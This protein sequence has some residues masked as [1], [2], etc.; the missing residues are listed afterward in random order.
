VEKKSEAVAMPALIGI[1][2]VLAAVYQF[3][4]R[5]EHWPSQKTE[6]VFYEHDNLTGET[7]MTRANAR[8]SVFARIVG[9]EDGEVIGERDSE[10]S[11]E[12]SDHYLAPMELERNDRLQPEPRL[13]KQEVEAAVIAQD[14]PKLEKLARPVPVPH[15]VVVATT[16]PPVPMAML[17]ADIEEAKEGAHPF[18]VRQVDLNKDG[19]TEEIIQN[20]VQADGLLDISIVRNGR[21]IFF[22]R[23]RQISLLPS[24]NNEGW[25]DI[26]LRGSNERLKV[27]RYSVKT[28]SYT[29][30][31]D[32]AK[33]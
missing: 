5:Y 19:A 21:E 17:A 14:T 15:E 26:A 6:G 2:I 22:G 25:S 20:A 31:D 29:A 9:D 18:A 8:T 28:D 33:G 23:G 13:S 16:A 1:L 4:F 30:L 7:R 24:R 11:D 32:K 10:T 12:N 27:F 3:C